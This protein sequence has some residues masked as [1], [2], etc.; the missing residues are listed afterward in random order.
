MAEFTLITVLRGNAA[1][2]GLVAP[3]AS[4]LAVAQ[5]LQMLLVLVVPPY[6]KAGRPRPPDHGVVPQSPFTVT[7]SDRGRSRVRVSFSG[8]PTEIKP[9]TVLPSQQGAGILAGPGAI[10]AGPG[11]YDAILAQAIPH[12]MPAACRIPHRW[13]RAS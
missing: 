10:L 11:A 4:Q 1:A 13:K 12:S 6:G 9:G 7:A 5:G 8:Q 2:G 3:A